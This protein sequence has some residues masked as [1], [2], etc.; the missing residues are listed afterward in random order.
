MQLRQRYRDIGGITMAM[1]ALADRGD[2]PVGTFFTLG[3]SVIPPADSGSFADWLDEEGTDASADGSSDREDQANAARKARD[4]VRALA[5]FQKL[6]KPLV[7]EVASSQ[8]RLRVKTEEVANVRQGDVLHVTKVNGKWLWVESVVGR[9]LGKPG[10][11][12]H[13][14]VR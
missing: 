6:G 14:H 8:A 2:W 5:E 4:F 9:E 7:V 13:K 3:Y 1:K 12:E 11:I 10:W